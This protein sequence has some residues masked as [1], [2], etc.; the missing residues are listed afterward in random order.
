M[1][2]LTAG[3]T[4][5]TVIAVSVIAMP[6]GASEA[7]S[8]R[9]EAAQFKPSCALSVERM[10]IGSMAARKTVK[11]GVRRVSDLLCKRLV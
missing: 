2:R 8:T 11:I 9:G 3:L 10:R 6:A 4:C 1:Q 5:A 7:T